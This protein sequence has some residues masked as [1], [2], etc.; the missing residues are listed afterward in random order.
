MG[1]GRR[2]RPGS[3]TTRH[4]TARGAGAGDTPGGAGQ[5]AR[6]RPPDEGRA[7]SHHRRPPPERLGA[8][9]LHTRAS[10]CTWGNEKR[11]GL[12]P[13]GRSRSQLEAGR[14]SWN[15][16][17]ICR[18]SP[19]GYAEDSLNLGN[20][21]PSTQTSDVEG[22]V[23]DRRNMYRFRRN[24]APQPNTYPGSKWNNASCR[25]YDSSIP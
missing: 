4:H 24:S 25:W 5:V 13:P 16:E 14:V 2:R 20:L 21:R 3:G 9:A 1:C 7:G 15:L 19:R 17:R 23:A 8:G 18:C 12:K 10:R 11:P 22:L 6:S